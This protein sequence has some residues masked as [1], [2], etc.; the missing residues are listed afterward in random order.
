M[1]SPVKKY[2]VLEH[3]GSTVTHNNDFMVEIKAE[4]PQVTAASKL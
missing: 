2:Q 3:L 1:K 4:L